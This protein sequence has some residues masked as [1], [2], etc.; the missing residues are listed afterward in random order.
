LDLPWLI[1][2]R[3]RSQQQQTVRYGV[4]STNAEIGFDVPA[5]GY[6]GLNE[7]VRGTRAQSQRFDD[8]LIPCGL[9]LGVPWQAGRLP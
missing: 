2:Q 9:A 5:S 6:A 3:E 4:L 1:L 7:P 8:V